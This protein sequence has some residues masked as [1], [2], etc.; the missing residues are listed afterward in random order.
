[1]NENKISRDFHFR[2]RKP[3]QHFETTINGLPVKFQL[4]KLTFEPLKPPKP[5][6]QKLAIFD[7]KRPV[8]RSKRR[9]RILK[10]SPSNSTSNFRLSRSSKSFP[11]LKKSIFHSYPQNSRFPQ[12]SLNPKFGNFDFPTQ[13]T[14]VS[15]RNHHNRIPR[16]I[17]NKKPPL[18]PL[19]KSKTPSQTPKTPKKHYFP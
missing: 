6:T 12:K 19:P 8:S 13:E 15:F 14:I 9:F 17:F 7:Q 5:P 16:K 11:T 3:S 2:L 18:K 4:K 10:P 1:M